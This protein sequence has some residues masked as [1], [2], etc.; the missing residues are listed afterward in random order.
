MTVPATL[1][2]PAPDAITLEDIIRI[3]EALRP[4]M[5]AMPQPQ[6][7][8]RRI[9]R[10][11]DLLDHVEALLLDGFGVINIGAS[12][13]DGILEFLDE[14]A[15]RDIAVMVLTNGAGQPAETS[16]QKYRN[17]GLALAREQVVSSRNSLEAEI[18]ALTRGAVVGSMGPAARPLDIDGSLGFDDPDMFERATFLA[19]LGAIDWTEPH[20]A[21]LEA[22]LVGG[23]RQLLVANPDISAPMQG[24][25]T[26][27]PGYWAARAAQATGVR[28]H[29]FGKPHSA[30]FDLALARLE[31][32]Y[33]RRFSRDKVA[34]VGDS[35]HTDI[36]GGAAAGLQ[37]VLLTG[38]GLFSNG[39]ADDMIQACGITPHWIV[40]RL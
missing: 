32:V 36:L 19:F 9:D 7:P 14:V 26:A 21:A 12:R 5:P 13:I 11:V 34:M 2:L 18:A 8:P 38:Y 23:Q 31:T 25:F 22:A 30:V 6:V 28:P 20:Q 1:R 16:W 4:Q 3:Y 39:G 35:L 27:E 37:S 33:G 15:R 17:W 10:L 24:G 40:E 29:W